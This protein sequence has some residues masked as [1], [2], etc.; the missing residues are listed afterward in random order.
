MQSCGA[1]YW[2][3][4]LRASWV[5]AVFVSRSMY[6]T[7]GARCRVRAKSHVRTIEGGERLLRPA[8]AARWGDGSPM[9]SAAHQRAQTATLQS[10]VAGRSAPKSDVAENDQY[11]TYLL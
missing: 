4:N 10:D 9:V 3:A 5:A 7:Y 8:L 2:V 1:A 11:N 6:G